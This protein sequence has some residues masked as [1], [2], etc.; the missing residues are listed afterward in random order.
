M[1][2]WDHFIATRIATAI[3]EWITLS[4][5]GIVAIQVKFAWCTIAFTLA[6]AAMGIFPDV[7]PIQKCLI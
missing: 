1:V 3:V 7:S 4:C 6:V 2:L 5:V